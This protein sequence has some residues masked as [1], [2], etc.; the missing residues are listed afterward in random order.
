MQFTVSPFGKCPTAAPVWQYSCLM[1]RHV[2]RLSLTE[3]MA[4]GYR[5]KLIMMQLNVK[6]AAFPAISN[7]SVQ[8]FRSFTKAFAT[9]GGK[10][11]LRYVMSRLHRLIVV[12]LQKWRR[13]VMSVHWRHLWLLHHSV[14]RTWNNIQRTLTSDNTKACADLLFTLIKAA[15][16]IKKR[17]V[18]QI[19][20]KLI[21]STCK[22]LKGSPITS[23]RS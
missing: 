17:R 15:R 16:L 18:N 13:W 20:A 2:I 10:Y 12:G 22:L 1:K 11:R 3:L 4:N 8:H 23:R 19:T 21:S 14:H 7:S 5:E 9:N 6:S